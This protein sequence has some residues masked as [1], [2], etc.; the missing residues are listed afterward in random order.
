VEMACMVYI[1][2]LGQSINLVALY[3]PRGT[4]VSSSLICQVI[5]PCPFIQVLL[6]DTSLEKFSI[7]H[8]MQY[9][10]ALFFLLLILG[11]FAIQWGSQAWEA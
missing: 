11:A 4:N 7:A 2:C 8:V 10:C 5:P 1:C 9:L 3:L 6:V